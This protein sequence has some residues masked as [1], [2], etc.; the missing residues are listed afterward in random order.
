MGNY[1]SH[2]GECERITLCPPTRSRSRHIHNLNLIFSDK[3]QDR[4]GCAPHRYLH[5]IQN[6]ERLSLV[7]THIAR[8]LRATR[9]GLTKENRGCIACLHILQNPWPIACL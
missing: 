3:S 2:D 4:I 9:E 1:S 8:K 5:R 7:D 6:D